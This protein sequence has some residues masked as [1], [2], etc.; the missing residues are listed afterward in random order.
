MVVG[1]IL[2]ILGVLCCSYGY[3]SLGGG[4]ADVLVNDYHDID[5]GSIGPLFALFAGV[6]CTLTG[7]LGMLTAKFRYAIRSKNKFIF[8]EELLA[9]FKKYLDLENS[10][11]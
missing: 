3:I 4:Q 10:Y 9:K 5:V 6:V 8:P 11:G 2:F 7:F 1:L